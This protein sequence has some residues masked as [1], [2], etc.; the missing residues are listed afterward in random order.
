ML[1]EKDQRLNL[2]SEVK[3][4]GIFVA[5][6]RRQ[7]ATLWN[8]SA[9]YRKPYLETNVSLHEKN[10]HIIVIK[11]YCLWC[12]LLQWRK[13]LPPYQLPKCESFL[14][15][16]HKFSV[17]F[18]IVGVAQGCSSGRKLADSP[19]KADDANAAQLHQKK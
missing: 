6:N 14:S 2:Y 16:E 8:E 13:F 9:I 17:V 1:N 4:P 3:N 18:S 12:R 10:V 11:L 15:T 7:S 5:D 19:S